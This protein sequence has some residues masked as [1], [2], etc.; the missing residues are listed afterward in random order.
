MMIMT[1]LK[2][3]KRKPSYYNNSSSNKSW[4]MWTIHKSHN[5]IVV[6]QLLA[7]DNHSNYQ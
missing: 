5:S 3:E 7:S 6:C 4:R 1:C 2:K